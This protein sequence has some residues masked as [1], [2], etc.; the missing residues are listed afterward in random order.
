MKAKARQLGLKGQKVLILLPSVYGIPTLL[1][2]QLEHEFKDNSNVH[3]DNVKADDYFSIDKSDLM[4]KLEQYK[5]HHLIMDEV[6]IM[7]DSDIDL[8]KIVSEKCQSNLCWVTVTNIR[9]KDPERKL[10]EEMRNGFRIIKDELQLPL[11]NTAS[12][13]AQAYKINLGKTTLA[14]RKEPLQVK[15]AGGYA[16]D[17][18]STQLDH[19]IRLP[20]DHP[21][22]IA[23]MT[24][25]DET[26]TDFHNF[27][28]ALDFMENEPQVLI[29][30]YDYSDS[31]KISKI[32]PEGSY[33]QHTYRN[34]D[35][36]G[37]AAWVRELQ[38]R[39]QT[40]QSRAEE[41]VAKK[42]YLI[43]DWDVATG[44]EAPAVIVVI[45]KNLSSMPTYC[46]RA[47]AKLV[48]Y[49]HLENFNS[50]ISEPDDSDSNS[51]SDSDS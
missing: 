41:N 39:Q 15:G 2:F 43:A 1:F 26:G 7:K 17:T 35:N 11:R 31:S 25:T 46:Q 33:I 30:L 34:S 45:P 13:A 48:V 51:D 24:I 18:A 3:V 20:M 19:Q 14:E 50:N 5:D 29:L 47:K 4:A 44:F 42:K 38:H 8:I 37:A 32:L 21:D 40:E 23:P 9:N 12:I 49:H 6:G 27:H 28:K 16:Y 22:G 10:N 36:K